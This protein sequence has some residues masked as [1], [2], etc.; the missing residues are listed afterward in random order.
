MF[1]I[2]TKSRDEHEATREVV[3][4]KFEENNKEQVD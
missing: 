4:E 3:R 1:Q 2:I